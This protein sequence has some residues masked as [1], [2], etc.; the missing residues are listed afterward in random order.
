MKKEETIT[1]SPTI[2]AVAISRNEEKDLPAFIDHLTEWV[3]EIIIVDD[4]SEDGTI[5]ILKNAGQKV[6]FVEQRMDPQQGYSGQRN[7]GMQVATADWL[8]HMDIDERIPPALAN[9]MMAAI[10]DPR[11][12]AYRYRRLNFFLHRPMRGGGFQDWN[13]AQLARRGAHRFENAVHET[14]VIEGAPETIGQLDEKIWHLNDDS[15]NERMGKSLVYC[16][17]Q[18][19]RL[20]EK[21][22]KMKWYHFVVLPLADLFRKMVLRRG[23]RDGTLGL[24][25]AMHSSCAMFKACALAFDAQNRISRSVVED[26]IRM[27]WRRHNR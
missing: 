14:C 2:G 15:Y 10:K 13:N 6:K 5:N 21:G 25:F 3:D 16:Q 17:Y 18:G 4:G 20:I 8:I 26:E 12:N 11:Y 22:L 24:L 9:E 7:R 19:K 27:Q 1:A 23:Y